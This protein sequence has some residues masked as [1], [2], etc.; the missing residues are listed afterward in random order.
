MMPGPWWVHWR[1]WQRTRWQ[2]SRWTWSTSLSMDTSGIHLQT[3]KCMQNTSWEWTGVSDQWKSLHR[4]TQNSVGWRIRGKSRSVS[5]IGLPLGGWGNRSR[6][7]IPTSGQFSKSEEKHL[8]LRVESLICARLN[9]MRIKQSF[10]Q[11]C[12]PWTSML[13]P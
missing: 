5:K 12:I 13:V 3:Q 8:R 2:R 4:T 9:G 6:D 7:P 10:W 1:W 11:S